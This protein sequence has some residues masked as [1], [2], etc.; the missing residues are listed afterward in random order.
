[1]KMKYD[2]Q[3]CVGCGYV[4]VGSLLI[5]VQGQKDKVFVICPECANAVSSAVKAFK[6]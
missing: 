1:M 6:A 2:N 3:K 5:D 4:F